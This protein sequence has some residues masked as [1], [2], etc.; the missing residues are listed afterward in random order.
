MNQEKMGKFIAR[1]RKKLNLTQ[2]QLAESLNV[3]RTTVSK[4]ERAITAPDISILEKL[5]KTLQV[6]VNDILSGEINSKNVALDA[7]NFYNKITKKKLFFLFGIVIIFLLI[8]F[9]LI[10]LV[11]NYYKAEV[12]NISSGNDEFLIDGVIIKHR[13][14]KSIILKNLS[15]N[16]KSVGTSEEI[17]I[18]QADIKLTLKDEILCEYKLNVDVNNYL[19]N[20]LNDTN[21]YVDNIK[22]DIK[23]DD[24]SIVIDY[25]TLTNKF[26][27]IHIKL[28]IAKGVVK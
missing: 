11:D 19:D 22:S 25:E 10:V 28:K 3:S 17:E 24:L 23:E 6:K 9:S 15:Y 18:K 16:S 1:Q 13:N 8:F 5:A 4:W 2:E 7:I 14:K 21:L 26:G 27:Q 20:L 12:F